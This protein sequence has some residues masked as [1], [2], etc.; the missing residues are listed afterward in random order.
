MST[1]KYEI[2]IE[3]SKEKV[4]NTLITHDTYVQWV[5]AFS[6]NST[7]VGE[8]KQDAEI[9]FW[10][11]NMGGTTAILKVFQPFTKIVACH[12]N[13]VTKEGI[14]ENTGEMTE[15]WI[16]TKE[17]YSLIEEENKTKL[18]I[19][20]TTDQAFEKMFN[21]CWPEALENIKN[22]VETHG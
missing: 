1:L 7:F 11:P 4:W 5:K 6:P 2:L 21:K 12:I 9:R 15:K 22:I 18:T 8:W 20:M 19:E 16:G 10:D 17:S 3:G 13:T 14:T